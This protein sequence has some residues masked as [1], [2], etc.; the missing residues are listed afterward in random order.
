[1]W[2]LGA[3]SPRDSLAGQR[4]PLRPTASPGQELPG[5]QATGRFTADFGKDKTL[6]HFLACPSYAPPGKQYLPILELYGCSRKEKKKPKGST[7]LLYDL[8]KNL[9]SR[10]PPSRPAR[11]AQSRVPPA[12]LCL[13]PGRWLPVPGSWRPE[14]ERSGGGHVLQ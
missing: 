5:S 11:L 13:P 10:L 7:Q 8:P 6:R 2:E 9:S 12:V 14:L 3:S 4:T 1:M